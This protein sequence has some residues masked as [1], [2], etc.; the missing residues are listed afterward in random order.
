VVFF[1]F[2][3]DWVFGDVVALLLAAV[4]AVEPRGE[5]RL[6]QL[7]TCRENPGSSPQGLTGVPQEQG[8]GE[9]TKRWMMTRCH[10]N[11]GRQDEPQ[12]RRSR[13][14]IPSFCRVLVFFH[15]ARNSSRLI[16]KIH[17]V[18]SAVHT[19]SAVEFGARGYRLQ[20]RAPRIMAPIAVG[21]TSALAPLGIPFREALR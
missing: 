5:E 9:E 19:H 18:P 12:Q 16:L 14:P 7:G 17:R 3:I 4:V 10:E 20:P 13:D 21:H 1:F 15:H 2:I 11:V 8:T 6:Q